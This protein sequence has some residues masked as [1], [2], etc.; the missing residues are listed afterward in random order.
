MQTSSTTHGPN[1]AVCKKDWTA[2]AVVICP[3]NANLIRHTEMHQCDTPQQQNRGL[4]P[5]DPL[6]RGRKGI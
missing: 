4:N 5:H 2:R 6:T 1:P 3:G